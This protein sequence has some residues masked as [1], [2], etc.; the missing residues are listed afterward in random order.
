[1]MSFEYLIRELLILTYKETI[2]SIK[3]WK[4]FLADEVNKK[5]KSLVGIQLLDEHILI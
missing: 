1:M 4:C 2:L 3:I 5:A